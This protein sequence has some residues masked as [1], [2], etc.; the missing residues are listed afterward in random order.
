MNKR[1]VLVDLSVLD[2]IYCGFGQ[3]ALA[4]GRYFLDNYRPDRADYQLY[5]L[6]PKKFFGAFGSDVQYISSDS[7]LRRHC[8]F[9]FP[10]VEVWHSIHQLSRFRPYSSATKYILTI[11]D[12]NYLYE[13]KNE[14]TIA[15]NHR[16]I[17]RKINRA[18]QIVCISEFVKQEVEQKCNIGDKKCEVIHNQVK[19]LDNTLTTKPEKEFKEP[20]FFAIGV[21][22]EKKNF[23]TLLDLMK[24][25]P[26]KHLY[27]AGKDNYIDNMPTPYADMIK[28]R[29]K[30]ENITNI[31]L[32]GGISDQEKLWMYQH[33]EAFLIPSLLEGFGLPV[34]EAMQFGKPVFSSPKTSLTEIGNR[35]A[36]FWND[37]DPN[38]MKKLIEDN[39]R[40]FY[41]NK[42]LIEDQ[43]AYAK[44][45]ASNK[46]FE[47]YEKIYLR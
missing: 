14:K 29:I 46:H 20:F 15:T 36:F 11:H 44:S 5:L 3:V 18:D 28:R 35:F 17:N 45:F 13:E 43:I 22:L 24:L 37:F 21:I 7:W 19:L 31:T 42:Q 16:R 41:D 8:R 27:I 9:L 12:L 32:L 25:M 23:H 2:N 40:T 39:L 47:E 30:D 34:I 33:C 1:K 6:L 38:N 4:Y 10:R 26:D